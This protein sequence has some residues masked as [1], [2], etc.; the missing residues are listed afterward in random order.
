MKPSYDEHLITVYHPYIDYDQELERSVLGICLID[1]RSYSQVHG[2]LNEDCFF[3]EGHKVVFRALAE[4]WEEGW[5]IDMMVITRKLMSNNVS[6]IMNNDTAYYVAQLCYHVVNPSHFVFWC[7]MLRELAARRLM[8]A[9]T[10]HRFSGEDVLEGADMIHEQLNRA[11]QIRQ[12]TDWKTTY[13]AAHELTQ[14]MDAI[15][16]E[17]HVGVCT[18]FPTLDDLNGGFRAGQLVVIGARPSAGKSA[19][20]GGMAL[21]A[22]MQGKKVG[23]ISLEMTAKDI[24]GRM[25]SRVSEVPF[26]DIDRYGL[27]DSEQQIQVTKGITDVGI[28]PI[29]FSD[30]SQCTIHDIRAKAEQ[31]KQRYGLDILMLDYLQL[32]GETDSNRNRE[33]GIAQISRGLKMLAMNLEIPVVALSQL[34][35]ASEQRSDKRPNMADLRESGAIEQDAD[36]VMLLHRD[37]RVGIRQ[38]MMGNSTEHQADL[39]IC[40]WRNGNPQD[41]KLRFEP[42]IMKFSEA[43]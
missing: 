39:I 38:D 30:T 1:A 35:R 29:Y 43:A 37:W 36:I 40:K 5:P 11:L 16:T 26:S 22:A 6:Q 12:T 23:I 42:E 34:N 20:M 24:F 31:L 4:V 33:Q 41:I 9:L 3:V 15:M 8:I 2:I 28:L 10:T 7:H 32:V 18:G 25:V 19:L 17:Q 27:T 13:N 14:H 21:G